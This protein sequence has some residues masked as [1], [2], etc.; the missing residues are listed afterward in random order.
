MFLNGEMEDEV[1]ADQPEGFVVKGSEDKVYRLKKTLY[2]LRQAPKAW[3]CRIYPYFQQYRFERSESE[4]TLYT[5]RQG[6]Y[7]LLLVCLYVDDIIYTG[8]TH[9]L[10]KEF[11][12][13]MMI[14]TEMI[15]LGLLHYFLGLE[16]KQGEDSVFVSQ[17]K[18]A[19][20]LLKH[21][22]L[23]NCKR[24]ITPMNIN[25]KLQLDDGIEKADAKRF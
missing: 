13:S 21:F 23:L 25:E 22:N 12:N 17:R 20:D 9:S 5:K 15:D 3:Y 7:D 16:I 1:Y 2:G 6:N 8:S 18:Y 24:A 19:K 10:I 4:P 11:K 14:T